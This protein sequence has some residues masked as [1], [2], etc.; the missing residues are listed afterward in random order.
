L[1]FTLAPGGGGGADEGKIFLRT[2][3]EMRAMGF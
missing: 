1:G 3:G 2:G